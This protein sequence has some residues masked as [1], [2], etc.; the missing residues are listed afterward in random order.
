M[1][2][3]QEESAGEHA[4]AAGRGT[5]DLV[6]TFPAAS[7]EVRS[8]RCTGNTFFNFICER[9]ECCSLDVLLE[10]GG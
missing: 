7:S 8:I 5:E 10:R 3:A 4:Y 1:G 9:V 6:P 2:V